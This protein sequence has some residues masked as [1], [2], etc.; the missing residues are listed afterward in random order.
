MNRVTFS[1]EDDIADV[2]VRRRSK[3]TSLTEWFEMNRKNPRC[4]DLTY[5]EFTTRYTWYPDKRKWSARGKDTKVSRIRYVHPTTGEL[6]YLR[7]RLMTVRRACSYEDLMTHAGKLRGT[8][9]EACQ[10]RGLL[11]DDRE[12]ERVF[13]ETVHWATPRQLRDLFVTVLMYCDVGDAGTLFTKFWGYMAED[14]SYQIRVALR[15]RNYVVPDALLQIHLVRELSVLF[16]NNGS[17]ISSYNLPA[18]VTPAG[19]PSDNRLIYE[20]TSYD[21]SVLAVEWLHLYSNF[22]EG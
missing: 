2:V 5:C 19:C 8:F 6:F 17:S 21:A 4:R 1:E 3:K 12:W 20:E 11:G 18:V 15:N 9:R 10:A 22:N 16:T 14:L 7:M 13:E